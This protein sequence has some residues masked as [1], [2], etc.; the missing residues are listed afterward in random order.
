MKLLNYV[1]DIFKTIFPP[2]ELKI[3]QTKGSNAITE[4]QERTDAFMAETDELGDI[5]EAT[6]SYYSLHGHTPDEFAHMGGTK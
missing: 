1:S 6:A 4:A 2:K 5:S 3:K